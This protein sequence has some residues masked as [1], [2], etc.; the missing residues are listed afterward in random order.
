[1]H[2]VQHG[3]QHEKA[4]RDQGYEALHAIW[5]ATR[6]RLVIA[7]SIARVAPADAP[8]GPGDEVDLLISMRNDFPAPSDTAAHGR[9]VFHRIAVTVSGGP[10]VVVVG[11]NEDNRRT[12]VLA[13]Q[14]EPLRL[15]RLEPRQTYVLPVRLQVAVKLPPWADRRDGDDPG[16]PILARVTTEQE[17]DVEAYFR[18]RW[19]CTL[20]EQLCCG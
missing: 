11:G 18:S 2:F 7:A 16:G 6:D 3:Y 8:L 12:F 4:A 9:G 13:E 15:E 5:R 10:W 20:R 19:S 1:M 17:L 14:D